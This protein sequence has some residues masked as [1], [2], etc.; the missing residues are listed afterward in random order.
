MFDPEKRQTLQALLFA[1]SSAALKPEELLQPETWQP[2]LSS[3]PDAV[4]VNEATLQGFEKLIQ[5]CW[6]FSK[7]NELALVEKLLPDC[8]LKLVPIAQQPS[9][10]QRAAAHLAAQGYHLYSILAL[11]RNDPLAEELYGKQA[12]QYS[13]LTEDHNLCIAASKRLGDKY[14]YRGQYPQALQ[15]YLGALQHTKQASPLLQAKAYMSLAVAYAHINQKQDSFTYLGLAH[16]TF[17][18]HPETDASFSHA[19]FSLSQMILWEGITR[20][21]LEQTDQALDIFDRIKQPGISISERVRIEIL[22]QRAKTA[23][24]SGDLEQGSIYVETGITGAKALGSQRRY[25][26]A[27]DNY[28]Q[29]ALLWPQ[30]KRVKELRELFV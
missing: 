12:V 3:E 17:P 13:L 1:L 15:T 4:K 11:H 29:M 14:Y 26:E 20:T 28:K 21:Q 18:D 24:V 5:A 27:Y 9:R 8:M 19:E 10:H 25:N 30:E 23:I 2:L 16:D 22:N 6:Q 7:G